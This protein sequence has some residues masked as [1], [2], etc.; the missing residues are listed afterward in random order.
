M[1]A[2]TAFSP[3]LLLRALACLAMGAPAVFA[4]NKP[5]E[6]EAA[7]SA[8]WVR[9]GVV[10]AS[11][12]GLAGDK[13][14][15][16]AYNDGLRLEKLLRGLGQMQ[17]DHVH[18]IRTES[19]AEMHGKLEAIGNTIAE[20]HGKGRKVLLQFYYT[21][22]GGGRNFHVGGETVGFGEVKA[23]LEKGKPEA[24]IYV[25]DVCQGAS[26]FA[27]KGFST[28]QPVRVAIEI[29]KATKGEVTISSS[30]VE[31]QAYEVKTLGGSIFTSNWEMA[32]R[33]A[34]DRNR[35]GQVTLFEAYN[36]AY[37][38]TVAFSRETLNLPQHPSFSIDL[39]GAKDL[40]L[41]RPGTDQGGLLFRD[42]PV[43][44]YA[45]LDLKRGIPVGEMRI[46]EAGDFSLAL[47]PGSYRIDHSSA[48]GPVVSAQAEVGGTA[49][50][51]LREEQ[52]TRRARGFALGKGNAPV[53]YAGDEI[54]GQ[55]GGHFSLVNPLRSSWEWITW[56]AIS[57]PEL[58]FHRSPFTPGY[59]TLDRYALQGGFEEAASGQV[60]GIQ[61]LKSA[62]GDWKG[63]FHFSLENHSLD[64]SAQ[65]HEGMI[66][67]AQGP[68]VRLVSHLSVLSM[69]FGPV[70]A[71]PVLS[72]GRFFLASD[73]T[74]GLLHSDMRLKNA[75]D[76][77]AY[78]R[79]ESQREWLGWGYAV[80]AYATPGY[81]WRIPDGQEWLRF[82]L[83]LGGGFH[84][85][86][87]PSGNEGEI[88]TSITWL[89]RAGL[90]ITLSGGHR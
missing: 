53:T 50:T 35:D 55:Q 42:C 63:G 23:L 84:D 60:F 33:G 52:F 90:Q 6:L 36:Y 83:R 11:S 48:S 21:G 2:S 67:L 47:E 49:F 72:L 5:V 20:L 87:S 26:F 70:L 68:S 51:P 74:L 73:A 30:A 16:Y 12:Q 8:D 44:N 13:P 46:P 39:T 88:M 7:K 32:L 34:G 78:G 22:H 76:S 56:A 9:F 31:E 3:W 27:S 40:Q 79:S 81:V 65:G 15:Q 77:D 54:E 89:W 71:P 10:V 86:G 62:W 17:P 61:T 14:L 59:E 66:G 29:D 19:A 1:N 18:L 28:T 37:D 58:G 85:A 25:L 4:A 41:T 75:F 43:G 80:E 38:R 64:Y 82:G 69:Q 45:L 24:R 57:T